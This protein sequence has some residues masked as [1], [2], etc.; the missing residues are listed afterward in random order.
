MSPDV[1]GLGLKYTPM[2]FTPAVEE[3]ELLLDADESED[4][5]AETGEDT[6]RVLA[7]CVPWN[8]GD[9]GGVPLAVDAVTDASS[10]DDSN[11]AHITVI[12]RARPGDSCEVLPAACA[13]GMLPGP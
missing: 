10:S 2:L 7:L 1:L 4:E 5:I 6:A 11:E 9:A 12:A 3:R 13:V 8:L